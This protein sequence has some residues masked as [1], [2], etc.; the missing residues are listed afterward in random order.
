MKVFE[1]LSPL[2]APSGFVKAMT[3]IAKLLQVRIFFLFFFSIQ[4]QLKI[5]S[6][7]QFGPKQFGLDQY[8][9]GCIER[10]GITY[11]ALFDINSVAGLASALGD[12]A[13]LNRK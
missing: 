8:S 9:F 13:N 7:S 2:L 12:E 1:A 6:L 4:I 5:L 3:E 10:Q 11:F